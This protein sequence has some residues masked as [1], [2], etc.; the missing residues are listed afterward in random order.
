MKV[1]LKSLKIWQDRQKWETLC[2]VLRE[3]GKW[4]Y[5]W[6]QWLDVKNLFI[7]KEVYIFMCAKIRNFQTK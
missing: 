6:V 4:M 1:F 5:D 3:G 2:Q 7:F